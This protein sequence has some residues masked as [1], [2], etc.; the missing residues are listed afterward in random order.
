MS[1]LGII[2]ASTATAPFGRA[3]NGLMSIVWMVSEFSAAKIDNLEIAFANDHT[4]LKSYCNKVLY[5][6]DLRNY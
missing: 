4:I 6:S 2:S 1:E 3:R 5:Q